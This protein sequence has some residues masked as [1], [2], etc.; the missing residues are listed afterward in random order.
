MSTSAFDS[1]CS[2]V[3]TEL[4]PTD[5][6]LLR[7]EGRRRCWPLPGYDFASIPAKLFHSASAPGHKYL[8][9]LQSFSSSLDP[10]AVSVD[11]RG[12]GPYGPYGEQII[13]DTAYEQ[14][15]NS[16]D[17]DMA[18]IL[19]RLA[20]PGLAV[21]LLGIDG[22]YGMALNR[23]A[24]FQGQ[25][26]GRVFHPLRVNHAVH[27]SGLYTIADVALFDS[28]QTDAS[29]APG[30]RKRRRLESPVNIPAD[31]EKQQQQQQQQ[32]T[33]QV[34]QQTSQT[35]VNQASPQVLF[36]APILCPQVIPQV[37]NIPFLP[38][39]QQAKEQQSSSQSDSQVQQYLQAQA[40]SQQASAP[41]VLEQSGQQPSF[42]QQAILPDAII[43]AAD[44]RG[45][46]TVPSRPR[47]SS[48]LKRSPEFH[49]IPAT[50]SSSE[51]PLPAAPDA[52]DPKTD[53][54]LPNFPGLLSAAE[55]L[56]HA[57]LDSLKANEPHGIPVP[58]VGHSSVGALNHHAR[59]DGNPLP[60]DL[61]LAASASVAAVA[62]IQSADKPGD[63]SLAS[64]AAG[65]P[66]SGPS[67]PEKNA[68]LQHPIG[69][70]LQHSPIARRCSPSA[71]PTAK[72]K[73]ALPSVQS[74]VSNA[75][76][77]A[78]HSSASLVPPSHLQFSAPH[79]WRPDFHRY[80]M[81]D[82]IGSGTQ[83][84]VF[85]CIDSLHKRP[86][87]IK[88]S[89][90]DSNGRPRNTILR[91]IS[92]LRTT[93]HANIVYLT[94][95][96]YD[97]FDVGI[98]LP[99]CETDLRALITANM[100]F[101]RSLSVPTVKSYLRQIL[102]ALHYL[103]EK[104]DIVH[105]DL[106]A[107]NV[108]IGPDERLRLADFGLARQPGVKDRQRTVVTCE[109]RPPEVFL[110]TH[111]VSV[112][113][114]IWSFGVLTQEL[115]GPLPWRRLHRDALA[116][117]TAIM[118]YCG[119]SNP[120]GRVGDSVSEVFPGADQLPGVFEGPEDVADLP[121]SLLHGRRLFPFYP[122][123]LPYSLPIST[124]DMTDFIELRDRCLVADP[125]SRPRAK[126]LLRANVLR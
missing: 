92:A 10:A 21:E 120:R 111:V 91:E 113:V 108:L 17:D 18:L 25:L 57:A 32:S 43:R 39:Q 27:P 65:D 31:A 47:R 51:S 36:A 77:S 55:A 50:P 41:N 35:P 49:V 60:G 15:R 5:V 30:T 68:A 90:C 100:G 38:R 16:V 103:H 23:R 66:H 112:K 56:P 3:F 95:I 126:D 87:A 88:V 82:C 7:R 45:K 53:S 8:R 73:N 109:Y 13:L 102:D 98:V 42:G 121:E 26:F 115:L 97:G 122:R 80:Q 58:E 117:F 24:L 20:V 94:D 89:Q 110:R 4:G 62:F 28:Q 75:V 34:V 72:N 79:L 81:G 84:S 2:E 46:T 106:K 105:L 69:A 52:T 83:G 116:T 99:L 71:L 86:V 12:A 101:G 9:R 74:S 40:S 67:L 37:L 125:A 54:S 70:E 124:K 93:V 29:Q 114:D 1:L 107:E 19:S 64:A 104:R 78:P 33:S 63:T 44:R 119:T 96:L 123:T 22:G 85:K 6:A 61:S 118:S 76:P 59:S 48:S 11:T 14:L